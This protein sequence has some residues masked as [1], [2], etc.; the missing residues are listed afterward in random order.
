MDPA[1][2]DLPAADPTATRAHT[3]VVGDAA[4]EAAT[5]HPRRHWFALLDGAGASGWPHRDIAAW[6][7]TAHGVDAWWAQG[8]TVGYEQ[9]RGLRVPGQRGDG[10]FQAGASRTLPL[11]V[12]AA[13]RLVTDPTLRA[14]WLGETVEARTGT[15]GASVRWTMPD[16][17]RV[18][19]RVQPVRPGASRFAVQHGPL[20]DA[21]AVA[22][23][24]RL[25]ADRMDRLAALARAV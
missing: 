22:A 5:G 6:L 8:L 2:H 18:V 21:D 4:L 13:L 1:T 16:G 3:G 25:W 19:G 17:T 15:S 23:S 11:D 7:V 14:R 10:S 12:E 20:A 9:A 24:K